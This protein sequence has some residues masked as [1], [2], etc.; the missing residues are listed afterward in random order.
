MRYP[1]VRSFKIKLGLLIPATNKGRADCFE[2]Y[3]QD[4]TPA[5]VP[6]SHDGEE[7]YDEQGKGYGNR[8]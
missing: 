2:N 3:E 1:D 5:G 8:P 6:R 7:T 4:G